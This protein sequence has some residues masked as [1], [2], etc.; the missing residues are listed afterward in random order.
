VVEVLE[1]IHHQEPVLLIK[2]LLEELEII[3]QMVM[4]VV[5]EVVLLVL[6]LLPIQLALEMEEMVFHLQ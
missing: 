2:V 5:V 1:T 6:E 4:L 3:A